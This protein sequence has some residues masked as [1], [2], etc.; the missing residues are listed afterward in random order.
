KYLLAC[1]SKLLEVYRPGMAI[2]YDIGC[3]HSKTVAHSSLG[4]HAKA[5]GLHFFVGA[6]HGYAHNQKCQLMYHPCFLCLAGLEDFETNKHIFSKQNLM[7]HLFCH[8]SCY[9]CHMILLLFWS[10][11]DEDCQ[12][13]LADFIYDNYRQALHILAMVQPSVINFQ[14]LHQL[15]D[16]DFA[17]FLQEEQDYFNGLIAEPE[18]D[19]VAF[20]YLETLQSLASARYVPHLPCLLL[21]LTSK[22]AEAVRIRL[23]WLCPH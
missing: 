12:V 14:H 9:H 1:L 6:F 4:T 23:R 7:A 8:G 11:W 17:R 16:E 22:Q 19:V 10:W 18:E 5:L 20:R 3:K 2:S 15:S 21:F 13:A